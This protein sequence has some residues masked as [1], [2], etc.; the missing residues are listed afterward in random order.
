VEANVLP[1]HLQGRIDAP[2]YFRVPDPQPLFSRRWGSTAVV[3]FE[4]LHDM[5]FNPGLE[6]MAP[7][8][9]R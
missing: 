4:G 7:L 8:S 9:R 6:W 1:P 5:V 2:T 3:L